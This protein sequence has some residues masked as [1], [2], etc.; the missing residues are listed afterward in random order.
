MKQLTNALTLP[1][2]LFNWQNQVAKV[3]VYHEVSKSRNAFCNCFATETFEGIWQEIKYRTIKKYDYLPQALFYR[4]GFI[5][6]C[7]WVLMQY[8]FSI[9]G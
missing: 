8:S 9:W 2:I 3:L 1:L 5:H 6:F 7:E 4:C